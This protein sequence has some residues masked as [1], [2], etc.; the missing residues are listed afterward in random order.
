[1]GKS[2]DKRKRIFDRYS[3]QLHGLQI[4]SLLPKKHQHLKFVKTYVCPVCL[5]HFSP[6]DLETHLSNFLTLEDAPQKSLGGKANT[7]T[8]KRCNNTCGREIDFHLVERMFEQDRRK[9]LPNTKGQ[10][11]FI[12]NGEVVQGEYSVD[13]NGKITVTHSKKNNHP[14]K[15]ESYI[16]NTGKGSIVTLEHKPSRVDTKRL[17]IALLK[18]A[19]ILA[20]EK[21]GYSI[22]LD[23]CF[24]IVRQQLLH[25]DEEIY[26]EGFW[27][28]Q[29]IFTEQHEG[30]HLIE[31]KGYFGLF[32]VFAL[33]TPSSIK[34]FGVYLPLPEGDTES[35]IAKLKDLE[36]GFA[37]RLNPLQG[38]FIQELDKAKELIETIK[39]HHN[40]G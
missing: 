21:F 40:K 2:E 15:L 39:N 35:I 7:L 9:F 1:M 23:E 16:D 5:T 20:F 30:V 37:L 29:Q 8:C 11:K 22:M 17:E 6:K 34:R 12:L 32:C 38:N 36:G 25:P 18:T 24:D 27:T 19:Y 13:E 14:E 33:K 31:T 10:G 3:S 26:P 28:K 4:Q